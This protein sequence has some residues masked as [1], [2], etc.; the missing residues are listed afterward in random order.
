MPRPPRRDDACGPGAMESGRRSRG[1]GAGAG[2]GGAM[3]RPRQ[4][5]FPPFEGWYLLLEGQAVVKYPSH[6]RV[7]AT[8]ETDPDGP[9]PASRR[10]RRAA[11]RRVLTRPLPRRRQQPR[12]VPESLAVGG[13]RDDDRPEEA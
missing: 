6:L 8:W 7:A 2:A 9:V 12:R 5:G 13:W 4:P 10:A 1:V 3:G 11:S